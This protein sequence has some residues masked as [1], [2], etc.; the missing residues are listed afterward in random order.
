MILRARRRPVDPFRHGHHREPAAGAVLD[1][2]IVVVLGPVIT[3]K[4]QTASLPSDHR[5]E[6]QVPQPA[7][8]SRPNC[9][10]AHTAAGGH[11]TPSTLLPP[12]HRWGHGLTT[13]IKSSGGESGNHSPAATGTESASNNYSAEPIRRWQLS[14][15]GFP[16][17]GC[18]ICWGA[19][20]VLGHRGQDREPRDRGVPGLR[21]GARACADNRLPATAAAPVAPYDSR[22]WAVPDGHP[23]RRP[24]GRPRRPGRTHGRADRRVAG[25]VVAAAV[26]RR[27]RTRFP[28]IRL[29]TP[30]DR[31]R[32]G[33][34]ARALASGPTR[35]DPQHQR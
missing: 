18:E 28:R 10:S 32:L 4:Q 27:R 33:P 8:G 25:W 1:L 21:V 6:Q 14:P 15:T 26:G 30:A 34:R 3:D 12:G 5:P 29:G 11:A 22:Y 16:E 19:T 7:E 20:S 13:E 24:G 23:P 17:E 2:D 35:D 9:S 31:R